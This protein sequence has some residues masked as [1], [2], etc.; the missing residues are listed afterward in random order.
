MIKIRNDK[1]V[2]IADVAEVKIG[3]PDKI[4][5]AFLNTEPAVILTILKQPNIN[6]L[7]LTEEV[8]RALT[9]LDSCFTGRC[10]DK[11][12]DIQTGR[13]YKHCCQ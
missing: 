1:P 12:R 7:A 13:F 2:K 10:N 9:D 3:H 5:D 11:F 4:G 6:T 8:D